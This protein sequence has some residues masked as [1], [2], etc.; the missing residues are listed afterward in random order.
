MDSMLGL[1]DRVSQGVTFIAS[2]DDAD[3]F[4][5]T[6]KRLLSEP[7]GDS[8][9]GSLYIRCVRTSCVVVII[10]RVSTDTDT[11]KCPSERGKRVCTHHV[12]CKVMP[13]GT[14]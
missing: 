4:L 9:Q 13:I 6:T 8:R 12:L 1:V 3:A 11:E 5:D 2:I 10:L 14:G 7:L